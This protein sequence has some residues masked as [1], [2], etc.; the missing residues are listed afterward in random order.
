MKNFKSS[1]ATLGLATA[2]AFTSNVNA[3][4]LSFSG[5]SFIDITPPSECEALATEVM[6]AY[7]AYLNVRRQASVSPSVV[8]DYLQAYQQVKAQYDSR[9]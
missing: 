1:I 2:M 3:G 7:V 8:A 9:C 4:A 6:Q 5:G